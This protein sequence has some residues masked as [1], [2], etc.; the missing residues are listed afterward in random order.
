MGSC[1]GREESSNGQIYVSGF[2]KGKEDIAEI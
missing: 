1:P 2:R